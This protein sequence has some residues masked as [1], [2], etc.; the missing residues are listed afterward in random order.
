MLDEHE[1]MLAS[2]SD[3]QLII[4]CNIKTKTKEQSVIK[5]YLKHSATEKQGWND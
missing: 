1:I 4:L 2:L 3:A 5:P